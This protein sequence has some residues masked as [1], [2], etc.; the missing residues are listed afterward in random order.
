MKLLI[1]YAGKSLKKNK[2]RKFSYQ[3]GGIIWKSVKM[4]LKI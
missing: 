4:H 3:Q 2:Q 1:I